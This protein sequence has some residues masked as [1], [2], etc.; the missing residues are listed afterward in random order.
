MA[1]T[2]ENPVRNVDLH[3]LIS[4]RDVGAS[5]KIVDGLVRVAA[6]NTPQYIRLICA[7]RSRSKATR[8]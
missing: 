8:S 7:S 3:W 4:I 5:K 2:C 1:T 6:L